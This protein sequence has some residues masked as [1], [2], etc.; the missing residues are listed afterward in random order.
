MTMVRRMD[1]DLKR[2]SRGLFLVPIKAVSWTE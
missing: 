2:G 1:K